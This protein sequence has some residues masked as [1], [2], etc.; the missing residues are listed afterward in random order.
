M[1]FNVR[2]GMGKLSVRQ[3]IFST[4]RDQES[5]HSFHQ[6][7]VSTPLFQQFVRQTDENIVV[8]VL[9]HAESIR[10]IPLIKVVA[11]ATGCVLVFLR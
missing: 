2:V 9:V 10:Q 11:S 6:N 4:F 5:T 7:I 1:Q 3:P 8:T